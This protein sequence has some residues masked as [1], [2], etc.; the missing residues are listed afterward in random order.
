MDAIIMCAGRGTRMRPITDSIP[1]PLVPIL[2]KGSLERTLDILPREVDRVILVVGYR[3]DQIRDRIGTEWKGKKITYLSQQPLDGTG[4]A[5]RQVEPYLESDRFLIMNGDDLYSAV[6]LEKLVQSE[7]GVL[8]LETRLEKE[9]DAWTKDEKGLL[10]KLRRMPAGERG[11][12][13]IGAYCLDRNWYRTKPI[14]VPGK[15]NEWS[16]PHALLELIAMGS[17]VSAVPATWW[18]PVGTP[19]E[20]AAAEA[21]LR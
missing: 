15:A 21:A 16:L 6:D 4:G 19:A 10:T 9:E 13:N 8:L 2:G 14:Q 7:R 20:L 5:L 11:L 12:V 18:M 1:K 3:G 17:H